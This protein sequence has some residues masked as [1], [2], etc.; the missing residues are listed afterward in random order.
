M[1]INIDDSLEGLYSVDMWNFFNNDNHLVINGIPKASLVETLDRVKGKK[2]HFDRVKDMT[3][4]VTNKLKKPIV[5]ILT[6]AKCKL[7]SYREVQSSN[8]SLNSSGISGS[9]SCDSMQTIEDSLRSFGESSKSQSLDYFMVSQDPSLCSLQLQASIV[10]QQQFTEQ[11]YPISMN[12]WR[13]KKL[14]IKNDGIRSLIGKDF[15]LANDTNEPS[16]S[17]QSNDSNDSF[18][19]NLFTQI[20][21]E[22]LDELDKLYGFN[23][24]S[25]RN[26]NRLNRRHS[27]YRNENKLI[28]HDQTTENTNIELDHR[29]IVHLQCYDENESVINNVNNANNSNV[30]FCNQNNTNSVQSDERIIEK[31]TELNLSSYLHGHNHKLTKPNKKMPFIKQ[32]VHRFISYRKNIQSAQVNSI[33]RKISLLKLL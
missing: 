25:H 20:L 22:S 23:E 2:I 29:K 33:F 7:V 28:V 27:S 31:S 32:V 5:N 24:K 30:M 9:S 14:F 12:D 16:L 15:D 1:S 11:I 6:K 26:L 10:Q 18:K 19:P 13:S 3:R 17:E 8:M 21:S 4:K